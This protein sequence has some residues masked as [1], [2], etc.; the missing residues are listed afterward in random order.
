MTHCDKTIAKKFD[1]NKHNVNHTYNL[2]L[3]RNFSWLIRYD[4][5]KL[6]LDKRQAHATL[7]LVSG[8][9]VKLLVIFAIINLKMAK[10]TVWVTTPLNC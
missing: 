5:N 4:K 3:I 8:L 2:L 10:T 6:R 7:H 1:N 9:R